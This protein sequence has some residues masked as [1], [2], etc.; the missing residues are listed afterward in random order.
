MYRCLECGAEFSSPSL[1]MERVKLA[2][3]IGLARFV[4]P[5]CGSVAVGVVN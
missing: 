2:Y 3:N 4:C 1:V 5:K